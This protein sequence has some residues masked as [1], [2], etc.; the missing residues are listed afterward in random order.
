MYNRDKIINVLHEIHNESKE[1]KPYVMVAQPRRDKN[2]TAAQNLDGYEGLHIDMLGFSHGFCDISGE[3]VDVARNYLIERAIESGAKYMLFVG[4]DTV[5]P[6]DGFKV[7]HETA[8]KNPNSVVVGVYYIKCSDA[9]IMTREN[10]HIIIPNV[11][12]GQLFEAWQTGMDAMIIPVEILKRMR[13]E[14]PELPFTCIGTGI[15]DIPF[16]GEDNFFVYRLRKMGVK[17]LVNTDVQCLHMDLASGNYTA[18]PSIDLKDYYTNIPIGRP[19]TM[20]D[21]AYIDKRWVD[22]LPEG[23]NNASSKIEKVI[24]SGDPVKFNM[25]SGHDRLPGYIAVDMHSAEAD[26]KEDILEMV[27]PESIADEI[28]ASHVIEHVPQHRTMELLSKW[29]WALKPGGKLIMETPNLEELCKDYVTATDK[30]RWMLS[31]CIFGVAVEEVTEET[32]KK[33]SL[34]PHLFGYYPKIMTEMLH[35]VGFSSVEILPVTG[36][37]PGKNFRVEAVK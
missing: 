10:D 3:K 13:D 36:Q 26:I 4:E 7:L 32:K 37:H 6:Y 35:G 23:S 31:V 34:S 16:I 19:L 12:P 29:Y 25:G 14:D 5:L 30:E 15:G 11:D 28:F 17:L 22:R 21:K 1:I 8:E 9:M 2:E 27:L 33:G 20:E 18:H 24:A